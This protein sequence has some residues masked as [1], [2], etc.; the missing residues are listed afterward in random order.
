[1][2]KEPKTL[3]QAIKII[4]GIYGKDV[5]KDV[6]MVNILNDV[7]SLEDPNAVKTIL[8]D[9]VKMGYGE[10]MLAINAPKENY[11]LKVKAYSK[12][13]SDSLGYKNVI[14]QYILYSI[15]FG[16]GICPQEPYV[17]NQDNPTPPQKTEEDTIEIEEKKPPYKAII[18]LAVIA[19][20][21]GFYGFNYWAS[22]SDREQFE[23]K[24]FS[25]NS[26]MSS[27]N[28]EQAV[29]SYKEAYNG[30]NAMNR[31]SYQKDA[32]EKIDAVVDKLIKEGETN[33][34]SLAQACKVIES[35]LQLTLS[36]AD[37]ERL[38]TKKIDL[39]NKITKRTDNGRNTLITILSANKGKLDENGL[40]LLNDL[41]EL[42]PND[43]WLNFIKKKSYE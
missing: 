24:V 9:V 1:M 8:R 38:T 21:G 22:S 7:V 34:K 13:I 39:E 20:I 31:S 43:Y 11:H 41:L 4:V 6:Q 2:T 15:A 16:I 32:L 23:N 19:V 35:E 40:Q 10:K 33:N 42:S 14:V 12:D 3:P 30:Y 17:K 26:F 25:G 18:V 36:D 5:V 37:K 28:Y 27:G 29:E